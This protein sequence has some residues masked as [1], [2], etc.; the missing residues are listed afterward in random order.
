VLAAAHQCSKHDYPVLLA[1][2]RTD[3]PVNEALTITK[4]QDNKR[5]TRFPD[6]ITRSK[7]IKRPILT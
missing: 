1:L 7:V 5:G 3:A 2:W 6:C 4:R